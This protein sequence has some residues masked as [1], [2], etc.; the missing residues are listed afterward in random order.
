[1]SA[2]PIEGDEVARLFALVRARYG[3]HIAPSDLDAVR[4]GVE[5]VVKTAEEL[6]AITLDNSVEPFAVFRP[7]RKAGDAP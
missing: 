6:R 5:H 7:Y 3:P 2:P 4:N 1:M